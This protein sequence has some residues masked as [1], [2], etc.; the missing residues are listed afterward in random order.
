MKR[1]V[2][3]NE[4]EVPL[5]AAASATVRQLQPGIYSVLFNG[6]SF[7]TR[8]SPQPDGYEVDINGFRFITRVRDPRNSAARSSAS[9]AGLRQNIAAT[10]PGKVIR[11]LVTEGQDIE[12]GQGLIVIEAMKMQN[13]IKASKPGR[14]TQVRAKDGD[15]VAAGDI[16]IT[17]V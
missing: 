15:A 4:R 5:E 17:I 8:I 13:E 16:L 14:V 7:E 2:F 9:L 12:P 11:V 3:V 10:M 1:Q 6:R